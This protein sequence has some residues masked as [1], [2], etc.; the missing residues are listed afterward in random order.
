MA[1][2]PYAASPSAASPFGMSPYT[3]SSSA[4]SPYEMSPYAMSPSAASPYPASATS[5]FQQEQRYPKKAQKEAHRSKTILELQK[6]LLNDFNNL[7]LPGV[8]HGNSD[9]R[10]K[11]HDRFRMCTSSTHFLGEV[12]KVMRQNDVDLADD[13]MLGSE[14]REQ[15]KRIPGRL[16]LDYII[17]QRM[18][19][20]NGELLD[21][22]NPMGYEA[23]AKDLKAG[24]GYGYA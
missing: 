7:D 18:E 16:A 13:F 3:A 6:K 9:L 11:L 15:I 2:T 21:K 17:K 20:R 5:P 19:V 8:M 14:Q 22:P 12:E 10:R 4:A 1:P 23:I 24:M